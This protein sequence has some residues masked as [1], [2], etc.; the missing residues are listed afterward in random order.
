MS[1][2]ADGQVSCGPATSRQTRW[3][4]AMQGKNA[5]VLAFLV[6]AF[7]VLAGVLG[8]ST[9]PVVAQQPTSEQTAA[10]RQ[11]CRSDFMSNCSGVQP[12]GKEAFDCLM[13]NASRVSAPCKSALDAIGSKP[14]AT[15]TSAPPPVAPPAAATPAPTVAPAAATADKPTTQQMSALRAACRS[16]FGI[17]CPAVKP[18]GKAALR[19]LE[20]N[21]PA[22][23]PAC[24]SAV[25]SLGGAASPAPAP[26]RRH[27][28]PPRSRRS[29]LFRLC[30]LARRCKSFRSAN[31]SAQP[32]AGAFP[33]AEAAFSNALP[34]THRGFRRCAIRRSRAASDNL[35]RGRADYRHSSLLA[36]RAPCASASSFAQA[37]CG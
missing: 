35:P 24:R 22:L 12:G 5:D 27:Q 21:A 23:S 36:R 8:V 25:A 17:H 7:V 34:P 1:Q 14:P 6:L 16:D 37:S 2:W 29:G 28:R 4:D 26:R 30:G 31:P 10:I 32:Y 18:G 9:G 15:E 3:G 19:C 11:S 20:V 33:P 13:R